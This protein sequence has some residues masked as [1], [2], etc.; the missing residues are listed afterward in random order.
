MTFILYHSEIRALVNANIDN[1][2]LWIGMNDRGKEG[3]FRLLNGT[4]YD[5]TE[6]SQPALYM[7]EKGE[8]NN[9]PGSSDISGLDEDCVH[10]GGGLALNDYPC[11]MDY[12][13]H[14]TSILL[15]GLC[16][17]KV[18]DCPQSC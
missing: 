13:I 15:Y 3:N 6:T 18:L 14:D 9:Q 12:W 11:N 17:I 2:L 10:V 5:V 4:A 8:P 16:E 1:K 7:W